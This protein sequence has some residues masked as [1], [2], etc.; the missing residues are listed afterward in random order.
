[1]Q[2]SYLACIL[3]VCMYNLLLF[4]KMIMKYPRNTFPD[5]VTLLMIGLP[6]TH[7]I[8]PLSKHPDKGSDP[9][10][11]TVIARNKNHI[12]IRD[13][14]VSHRP[15]DAGYLS[16]KRGIVI[17]FISQRVVLQERTWLSGLGILR[18]ATIL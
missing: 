9:Y 8:L 2:V 17:F 3:D 18:V 11:N 10:L 5:K 6:S 12:V 1:M 4:V 16:S 15:R 14:D 13:M 7:T